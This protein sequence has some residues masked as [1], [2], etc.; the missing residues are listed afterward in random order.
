MV[1]TA[2]V[3]VKALQRRL[4]FESESVSLDDYLLDLANLKL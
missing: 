4:P 1:T 3:I 2:F